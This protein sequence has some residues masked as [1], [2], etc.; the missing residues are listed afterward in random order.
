M[1][2]CVQLS[3]LSMCLVLVAFQH[4]P[5][6][7]LVLAAN[8]DE[9]FAR[10]SRDAGFWGEQGESPDILAG[11]DLAQGGTWLG[12]NRNGRLAVVTNLRDPSASRQ[13][14]LSR[15][16]LAVDYLGGRMAP[17][18]YLAEVGSRRG[19]YAGFNLLLGDRDN[20][21]YLNSDAG[22][23]L[24]LDPGIYGLANGRLD[25]PWP[26]VRDGKLRLRQ[27]LQRSH[28]PEADQ[29]L[30]LLHYREPAADNELPETGLPRQ[31][32]RILSASFIVD[33][34]RGYGTRC[35]TAVVVSHSGQV[36]F[37]EQNHRGD[38]NIESRHYFEFAIG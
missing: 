38:G 17:A 33:P 31:L 32:E 35:S 3:C 22:A 28:E 27:L 19:S 7:P 6:L 9:F 2:A 15:G 11:K 5:Q 37:C 26:K 30:Q 25:D 23:P 14:V 34:A 8:R 1:A 16:G 29:L 20:L 12:M 18:E 36:R 21:W 24:R 10:P 13:G 4:N